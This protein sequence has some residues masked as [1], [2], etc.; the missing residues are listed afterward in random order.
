MRAPSGSRSTSAPPRAR[1]ARIVRRR[2]HVVVARRAGGVR[3]RHHV[4]GVHVRHA[5]AARPHAEDQEDRARHPLHRDGRGRGREEREGQVRDL[6][7]RLALELAEPRGGGRQRPLTGLGRADPVARRDPSLCACA[8]VA[9]TRVSA[10]TKRVATRRTRLTLDRI[11][12]NSATTLSGRRADI[13]LGFPPRGN[14]LDDRVR[15]AAAGG[16]GGR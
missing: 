16:P 12:P 14:G 2:R 13:R 4:V 8:G 7:R 9:A 15:A 11:A 10:S 5:R 6:A 1:T 3:R